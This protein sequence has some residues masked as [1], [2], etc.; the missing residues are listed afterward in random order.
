[1]ATLRIKD[2]AGNVTEIPA[3]QGKSAYSYAQDGGYTGTE[4]EFGIKLAYLMEL[5]DKNEVKY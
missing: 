3:I 4:E 1:M 2:D 5:E